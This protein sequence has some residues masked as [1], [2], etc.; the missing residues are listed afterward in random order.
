MSVV[1]QRPR[2]RH[3]NEVTSGSPLQ[4][5]LSSVA[6][7]TTGVKGG[8]DSGI[9][10][11]SVDDPENS[12]EESESSA[13][14]ESQTDQLD[15]STSPK[16]YIKTK[17][18]RFLNVAPLNIPLNRRLETLGIIWHTISI[19]AFVL[20]FLLVLSLGYVAWICI[21]VPYVIWWYGFDLHTPTNG[22]ATYRVRDWVKNLI[23]WQWFVNYFPIR[24]HK[25]CEYEPT[26][27]KIP[28]DNTPYDQGYFYYDNDDDYNADLN[29]ASNSSS[30]SNTDLDDDDE[31]DLVNENS[32]TLVDKIF[33]ALGLEKR[34]NTATKGKY[35]VVSTGPRYIFGY[36]PHGVISMGVMG[37]FATNVVRNEPFEPPL[38]CLKWLFHDP[39]KFKPLLPNI[40]NV[41]PLTLTTQFTLPF[42]RDY[43]LSLGLTSASATNIKSLIN[44]GDN[45]VCI[46]VGGAQE[47]LLNSGVTNNPTVGIGY[48]HNGTYPHTRVPSNSSSNESEINSTP[49][50]QK[51][52]K[53]V[54]D[55]RKGFVKLAIELGNINLV[56]VFG[57]GEAD[58]YNII[59]PTPGSVGDLFQRWLKR[60]FKFTLPFFSARGIF[61][62]DFGFLPY[63]NPINVC[64]GNPIHI[65]PNLIHD[66]KL[67][68][69]EFTLDDNLSPSTT[70]EP[71]ESIDAKLGQR[72]STS[73]TNLRQRLVKST[74]KPGHT[75]R[76]PKRSK[77]PP[78]LLDHY[79]KL[80]VDGLKRVFEENKDKYGYENVILNIVE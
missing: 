78:E 80:Y 9:A 55:K 44:N 27:K 56:P 7:H 57:F 13:P 37:T 8:S 41:F 45:S 5:D 2:Q 38:R 53:L 14:A 32:T 54:L 18:R 24:V 61:I 52:I 21:V 33:G 43:L 66:Y 6:A 1:D 31:Q 49:K 36:H 75:R 23:V 30:N 15:P 69:P 63:R 3:T 76:R 48:E 17:A 28:L 12:T 29:A 79:H 10:T 42:Y 62:Y 67:K 65:P 19:P 51:E 4:P 20:L 11:P 25:A 22:K 47:A 34:L 58:I 16:V 26:F 72:K 71:A 40:G 39:S 73:F 50:V 74:E 35:K 70:R 59:Q 68:H 46:V 64:M 60:N 77:I